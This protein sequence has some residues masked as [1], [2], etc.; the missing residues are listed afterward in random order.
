MFN[1][2]NIQIIGIAGGLASLV[3]AIIALIEWR[4]K[5]E[6]YDLTIK[7]TALEIE[8]TQEEL[9]KLKQYGT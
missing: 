6:Q 3:L 2:K 1:Q 8:K 4:K 5:S 7:K 9:K